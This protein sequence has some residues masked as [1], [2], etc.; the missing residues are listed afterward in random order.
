MQF[1]TFNE[2]IQLDSNSF[3][4]GPIMPHKIFT[5]SLSVAAFGVIIT[6]GKAEDMWKIA[7]LYLIRTQDGSL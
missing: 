7:L 1:A 4:L 5:Y 3:T 2:I 6:S